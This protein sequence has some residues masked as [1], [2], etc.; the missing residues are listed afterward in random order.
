MVGYLIDLMWL[1]YIQCY[2]GVQTSM[3][4]KASDELQYAPVKTELHATI[5]LGSCS[6]HAYTGETAYCPCDIA[7]S[8]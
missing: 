7:A 1:Y 8:G 5:G 2:A 6:S 4:R 3:P